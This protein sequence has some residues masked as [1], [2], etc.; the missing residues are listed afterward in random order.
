MKITESTYGDLTIVVEK[1]IR[2]LVGGAM[3]FYLNGLQEPFRRKGSAG[4]L[5][6]ARTP[7]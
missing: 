6:R 1:Y 2:K 3:V 4:F 7:S 5:G